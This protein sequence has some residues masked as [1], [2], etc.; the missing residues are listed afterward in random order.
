MNRG[1]STFRTLQRKITSN[2]LKS[3]QKNASSNE[4]LSRQL[5]DPYVEKAKQMNYRCRSA[6][7]LVEINNKYQFLKPGQVVIDVGAAPGSWSQVIA[8]KINSNGQDQNAPKGI[9]VAIDKQQIYPIDGVTI[10]GNMDFT[11]PENQEKITHFLEGKRAN[12]VVSDM[13]PS[14]SGIRHLDN[15]IIIELCYNV[16]RFAVKVSEQNASILVKLWQ[17]GETKQLEND[18]ARFYKNVKLVKPDSSRSD[19]AE[20]FLLGMD[21]KG[22]KEN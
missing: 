21:F 9:A 4:W 16:L 15:D 2:T 3:K 14:A 22:L 18:I 5:S 20:I 12:A 19:S 6:F 10:F 1:F 11:K 13:A 8:N 7:K 17:C